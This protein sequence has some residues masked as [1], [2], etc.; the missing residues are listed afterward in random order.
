MTLPTNA[1]KA[2]LDSA[3]DNPKLARP[4]LADLVDKFNDLLTHLN[5]S[6]ITSGP[7]AIPL[8]V[9]NGG[10]GSTTAAAARTALGVE[11][12]TETAAG[13]IEIANQTEANNGTDDTRALTPL[14]LAN[15]SPA[16]VTL[17]ATND[18]VL[19]LDASDGNKLKRAAITQGVTSITAGAGLT[20][21][22]ITTTG[23]VALDVYTGSSATN[24]DFP[25]GTT[26][27]VQ[28]TGTTPY[29]RGASNAIK[30]A[31]GNNKDFVDS[32]GTG[33][34]LTGTWRARGAFTT[35]SLQ[36]IGESYVSV[37][38]VGQLFQRTA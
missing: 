7:A 14:K 22:T 33:T 25:V 1:S 5:L 3:T 17:D 26:V 12:A 21:G 29:D 31:T 36:L 35:V 32:A 20:G 37:T 16:S 24:T 38:T 28:L 9:A 2:N 13:R 19:I 18:R 4:D 8:S 30:Y 15:I 34:T 6:T 27:L 23:T 10:T 11:D